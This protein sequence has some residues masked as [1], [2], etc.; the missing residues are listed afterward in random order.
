M[1]NTT[2]GR[3]TFSTRLGGIEVAALI[4]GASAK[5]D[6][7]PNDWTAVEKANVKVVADVFD[8]WERKD[9]ATVERLFAPDAVVRFSRVEGVAATEGWKGAKAVR[10]VAER[11]GKT[12]VKFTIVHTQAEGPIVVHRRLDRFTDLTGAHCA[13]HGLKNMA[14]CEDQYIATFVVKGG[15]IHEWHELEVAQSKPIKGM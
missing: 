5:A 15:Q 1:A 3:W 14:V 8:A 9:G 12:T 6:W 2:A 4:L 11:P 13:S 7:G 10:A